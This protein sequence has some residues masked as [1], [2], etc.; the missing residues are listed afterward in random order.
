MSSPQTEFRSER[1]ACSG[2][3]PASDAI[4]QPKVELLGSVRKDLEE[5][6][7]VLLVAPAGFG[8]T[9]F[10]R[11][12]QEEIGESC[13]AGEN[14][15]KASGGGPQDAE[16][17]DVLRLNVELT[18]SITDPKTFSDFLFERFVRQRSESKGEGDQNDAGPTAGLDPLTRLT[19]ALNDYGG[20]IQLTLDEYHLV[21]RPEIDACLRR[22][23]MSL[24]DRVHVIVAARRMPDIGARKMV[25]WDKASV[26]TARD[27]AFGADDIVRLFRGEITETEAETLT[28]LSGG[29]PVSLRLARDWL[30]REAPPGDVASYH[31]AALAEA[32]PY[33]EE[34]VY[35]DIP[36]DVRQAME[37]LSILP[38]FDAGAVGLVLGRS[39]SESII[40]QFPEV[41]IFA[42]PVDQRKET[43]RFHPLMR[44]FLER[45]LFEQH[46]SDHVKALCRKAADYYLNRRECNRAAIFAM[47]TG[48]LAFFRKIVESAEVNLRT[49]AG[50]GDLFD[51]LMEYLKD[52]EDF[53][54]PQ[55]LPAQALHAI[56][57]GDFFRAEKYLKKARD[58]L[59]KLEKSLNDPKEE[60]APAT[61]FRRIIISLEMDLILVE[62]FNNIYADPETGDDCLK[63]L[64]SVDTHTLSVDP[65][66]RGVLY[67]ALSFLFTRKGLI[68][69]AHAYLER[70]IQSF[71]K[72]NSHFSLVLNSFH[73]GMLNILEG[74]PE[75]AIKR[76]EP[77]QRLLQARMPGR[78]QLVA[79]T[80]LGRA[81]CFF[82]WGEPRRSFEIANR[83]FDSIIDSHDCW[84]DLLG[85]T[86][87]LTA[88]AAFA[89]E[90]FEA[91]DRIIMEGVGLA[92][93]RGYANTTRGLQGLHIHLAAI[94]GETDRCKE[95]FK[96]YGETFDQIKF[97]E[98]LGF[99][100]R[101][102]SYLAIGLIRKLINEGEIQEALN[103]IR[104]LRPA[105][106][107]NGLKW[108]ALK[109]DVLEALAEYSWKG[110]DE[111]ERKRR[112]AELA[113]PII[114][115][116]ARD[117][118]VCSVLLEEGDLARK[119]LRAAAY[120]YRRI[121][122]DA[123]GIK[124]N[125]ITVLE[126][127]YQYNEHMVDG[128]Q[129][130][131]PLRTRQT[132][133][134][135]MVAE[136]RSYKEMCEKTN[137]AKASI[138]Q[139][140]EA[141]QSKFN[142]DTREE[143]SAWVRYRGIANKLSTEQANRQNPDH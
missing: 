113:R 103:H 10:L 104:L 51:E 135:L 43:Y 30:T 136:N 134:L 14:E 88:R 125:I 61:D 80:E 47:H 44:K 29:W 46:G 118:A 121:S 120:R 110:G 77:A 137:A 112:A 32:F 6:S 11:A 116:A 107:Q 142:V 12:L 123:D 39:N 115:E 130:L 79:I 94:A 2:A 36:D 24:N 70:A 85:Q 15:E 109:M 65:L 83:V 129:D 132:D 64:R 18:G 105:Y 78:A 35:R 73:A 17:S 98:E 21:A 67:N 50:D 114:N 81:T 95:L 97:D 37:K 56:R 23:L 91:A 52:K 49:L 66:Y 71:D 20:K 143:L 62:A 3:V 131:P 45:R 33:L 54:I 76:F 58:S 101:E 89:R 38:V 74:K 8:K 106:E 16:C 100:W 40:L 108:F 87:R 31:M 60:D 1:P 102:Q 90:G 93:E 34:E 128:K 111:D 82:E 141:L 42:V 117:K 27:F 57:A 13:A 5:K 22:I 68:A 59:E 86:C 41:E 122:Q 127:W 72:A 84:P 55:L 48:D 28:R 140:I 69:E 53:E 138:F 75:A 124:D 26:Y 119:L 25:M 139:V 9:T 19:R 4:P 99:G 133:V 92:K 7:L 63:K 126:K 96:N